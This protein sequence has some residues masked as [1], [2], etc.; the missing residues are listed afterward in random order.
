MFEEPPEGESDVIFPPPNNVLNRYMN[1]MAKHGL[2]FEVALSSLQMRY[3]RWQGRNSIQYKLRR[4]GDRWNVL[5]RE[6]PPDLDLS[7]EGSNKGSVGHQNLMLIFMFSITVK[8]S[9]D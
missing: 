5:E 2:A 1:Q 3:E 4:R 7:D 8:P 9:Q 6:E